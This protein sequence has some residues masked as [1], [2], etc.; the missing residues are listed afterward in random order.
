MEKEL[1]EMY[2][3]ARLNMGRCI[4][5]KSISY[6]YCFKIVGFKYITKTTKSLIV[7]I[8]DGSSAKQI[9]KG[10]GITNIFLNKNDKERYTYLSIPYP[11]HFEYKII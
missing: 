8:K 4:R 1:K 7:I 10:I 5:Y 3:F 2:Y 9:S 11:L 6:I